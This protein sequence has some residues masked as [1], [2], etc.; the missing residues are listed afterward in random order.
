MRIIKEKV[1]TGLL[2]AL[3]DWGAIIRSLFQSLQMVGSGCR[4]LLAGKIAAAVAAVAAAGGG[5][6]RFFF[7][8]FLFF[9]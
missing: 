3:F 8:L 7:S 4:Q 6:Y 1:H 5:A 2:L 9:L